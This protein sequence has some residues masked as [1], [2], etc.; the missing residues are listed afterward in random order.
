MIAHAHGNRSDCIGAGDESRLHCDVGFVHLHVHSSYS[1]REGA[2]PVAKLAR[3]ALAD[4]MPA[5]AI[6]D[7]N[8]LFG[9]LEFSEKLAKEGVQPIPGLQVTIDFQD[10]TAMAPRGK[11][12]DA[13]IVLLAQDGAG[14]SNLMHIASRA[15]LDPEPGET[16]HVR[17]LRLEGRTNGLIALTGG[18]SGPL[19]RAF[20]HDRPELAF[21][22]AL[23]LEKLFPG[24]LY[25]EIQRHGLAS[26]RAIEPR[27]LDLAYR[28]SL[29]LVA[30][31]EVFFAAASD[32]E[33]HD[34][35]ICIADGT[36]VSDGAR[37][38]LS[39]EHRFKT[40]AEMIALFSDVPEAAS[41]SV[42]IALR[43]AY[44][45]VRKKRD[46]F[47]ARL[48]T[49]LGRELAAGAVANERSVR[50]AYQG[51]VCFIVRGRREKYFVGRN[52]RKRGA[53]GEIE[54]TR[55]D[56]AFG[57][58]PVALDFDIE[59]AGKQLLKRRC[60][61]K[62]QFLPV[63]GE[64]SVKRPAWAARQGDQPLRSPIE[65]RDVNM[66]RISRFWIEPRAGRNM[67]QVRIAGT[68]LGQQHDG[69]V[70]S[71][72][73]AARCPCRAVLKVDRDLQAW[74]RLHAFF[75]QL[76]GKLQGAE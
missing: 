62:R 27:L 52:K 24:R 39:P 72:R 2:V 1:L 32:Y 34:A 16:P 53:I 12:S 57:G 28:A 36:L 18:P 22:R 40:R 43:C 67:H 7:S 11:A 55:F 31:N 70:A 47:R 9:A 58:E 38:Q 3:L 35:L 37:R 48:E 5:L 14:Y 56:R 76:F 60:A 44:R 49:M 71:A 50:D 51:I 13:S 42:E 8:N 59:P 21:A 63:M 73:L 26:E 65:T 45:H 46:H 6:T 23:A 30:T 69:C 61:G 68:V 64:G 29:P 66:R 41:N 15:W 20:A 54:E 74:D 75:R 10:G 4:A 33:A 19:D 25:V 17:L